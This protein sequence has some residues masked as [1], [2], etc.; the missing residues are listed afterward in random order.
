VG[1][2]PLGGLPD[3]IRR[4]VALRHEPALLSGFFSDALEPAKLTAIKSRLAP[5]AQ[6]H[7]WGCFAGAPDHTFDTAD[8]YWN[9]FNPGGAA[10]EGIAREIARTLGISATAVRDPRNIHGMDFCVRDSSG[11]FNCSN[12][13]RPLVPTWQWPRGSS[14]R[15]VTWDSAGNPDEADILFF[16]NRIPADRLKPGQ[17]PR[18]FADEIPLA[19]AR[20]REPA[21]PT[22][23]SSVASGF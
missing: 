1:T 7:V 12:R 10:A 18:W 15:W 20:A 9:L 13:R 14:V 3:F 16:G 2:P 22:T 5:D 11:V 8:A 17:P 19:A 23:C 6:L 21:F 4:Y